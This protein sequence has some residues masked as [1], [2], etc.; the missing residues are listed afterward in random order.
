MTGVPGRPGPPEGAMKIEILR[1]GGVATVVVQGELDAAQKAE[2][3]RTVQGLLASGESRL[4]FDFAGVTYM[5]S[6]GVGCLV[7]AR[8]DAMAKSGAVAMVNPPPMIR[9]VFKTLGLEKDFPVYPSRDAAVKAL[10][11]PV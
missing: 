8:K 5:G 6:S 10:A 3:G 7:Q 9:K 2:V 4:V 11:K 1:Q